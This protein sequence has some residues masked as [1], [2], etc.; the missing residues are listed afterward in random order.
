MV[1][2][3]PDD[4]RGQGFETLSSKQQP[5]YLMPWGDHHFFGPT[6]TVFT[7]PQH[8][9]TRTLIDAAPVLPEIA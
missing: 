8:P 2:K 9:Y 7:D 5:F 1:V 3:L 6:E 4:C